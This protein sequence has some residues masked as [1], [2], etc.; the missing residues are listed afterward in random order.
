[1]SAEDALLKHHQK[2]LKQSEPRK[3]RN[4]RPEKEVESACLKWMREHGWSVDVIEASGGRNMYGAV[5]VKSG[6]SD[7]CGN[8]QHG[9]AV[10]V[11]FKAPGRLATLRD[12]QRVFLT[13]KINTNCFA[14]VV[15]SASRLSTLFDEWLRHRRN[16]DLKAAQDFLLNALPKERKS[17]DAKHPELGF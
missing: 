10:F 9:L 17:K 5:T 8:T 3:R 2:L 1:M 16:K 15:D 6:F 7:A 12:H 13:K 14:V 11:E 4:K